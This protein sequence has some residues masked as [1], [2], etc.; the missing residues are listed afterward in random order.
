[1]TNEPNCPQPAERA[2]AMQIVFGL[3]RLRLEIEKAMTEVCHVSANVQHEKLLNELASI[4]E[5]LRTLNEIVG[6]SHASLSLT[7]RNAWPPTDPSD[8][9]KSD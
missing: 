3:L 7:S 6:E 5:K 9:W 1:M 4:F 8:S 2:E